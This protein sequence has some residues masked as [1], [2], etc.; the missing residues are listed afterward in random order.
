M[1]GFRNSISLNTGESENIRCVVIQITLVRLVAIINNFFR[2]IW[3]NVCEKN[4]ES[5][6]YCYWICYS[7]ASFFEK[8]RERFIRFTIQPSVITLT[9]HT[10]G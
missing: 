9:V 4:I 3:A 1:Y 5:I 2:E 10:V 7:F 8:G 6:Y